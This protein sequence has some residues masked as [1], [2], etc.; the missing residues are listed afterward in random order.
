MM[1]LCFAITAVFTT[2]VCLASVRQAEPDRVSTAI[3]N[4]V[5]PLAVPDSADKIPAIK[6]A[7]SGDFNVYRKVG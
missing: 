1:I 6:T 7:V 2:A 3:E 5:R 4:T